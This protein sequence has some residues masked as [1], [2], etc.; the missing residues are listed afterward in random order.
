MGRSGPFHRPT[1]TP[2]DV[3]SDDEY[4]NQALQKFID[5]RGDDWECATCDGDV[6]DHAAVLDEDG[7]AVIVC[8]E[9]EE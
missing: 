8:S 9:E 1:V 6:Y 7:L 3:Q 4:L 5:E 2:A